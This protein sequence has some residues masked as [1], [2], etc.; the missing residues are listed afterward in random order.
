M[1]VPMRPQYVNHKPSEAGLASIERIRLDVNELHTLIEQAC[2]QSR[3]RSLALT[4]LEEVC[5]WAVKA[6]V[7]NRGDS[8]PQPPA[9]RQ[10]EGPSAS[11]LG[12]FGA[13]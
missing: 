10:D 8:T 2:P 6:I 1:A 5:M 3:E 7:L 9:P 4:H 12:I 13:G 11:E